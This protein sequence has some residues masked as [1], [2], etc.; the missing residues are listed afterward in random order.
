MVALG[1]VPRTCG[2]LCSL[3]GPRPGPEER[4]LLLGFRDRGLQGSPEGSR[5]HSRLHDHIGPAPHLGPGQAD[6]AETPQPRLRSRPIITVPHA[7]RH[8]PP[9]H[10]AQGQAG[11]G[12]SHP[13]P[14]DAERGRQTG[15]RGGLIDQPTDRYAS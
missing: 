5:T 3:L 8:T 15:P 12:L 14:A 1:S 4:V 9:R 6:A 7:A 10:H 11:L 2:Q 13:K